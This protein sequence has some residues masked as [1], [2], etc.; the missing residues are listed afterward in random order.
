MQMFLLS[1]IALLSNLSLSN[2]GACQE[3]TCQFGCESYKVLCERSNGCEWD[4]IDWECSTDDA[5]ANPEC[6]LDATTTESPTPEPTP[7]PTC[8][9]PEGDD[10]C[11]NYTEECCE[12]HSDICYYSTSTLCQTEGGPGCCKP[13]TSEPTTSEPTT[14][15]PTTSEPTTSEPTTNEPTT[16]EPTT[17]EPTPKPTTPKPTTPQPTAPTPRPTKPTPQPTEPTPEPTNPTPEPTNPTPEP[18]YPTPEPSVPT[19]DP[20]EWPTPRPTLKSAMKWEMIHPAYTG[21]DGEL[22]WHV[23]YGDFSND[24]RFDKFRQDE[25]WDAKE[26]RPILRSDPQ[27]KQ[28]S[29]GKLYNEDGQIIANTG[30]SHPS[31]TSYGMWL[32]LISIA[33]IVIFACW[34]RSSLA[35]KEEEEMS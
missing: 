4:T 29:N 16:S 23:Y 28:Y 8:A 21:S 19:P 15:E 34:Y 27:F 6:C 33:M 20:V 10:P 2:A 25:K 5:V 22:L 14:Q 12:D 7:A 24:E 31:A 32:V 26:I 17:S 9:E 3:M 18:T 30:E 1:L 11:E 35:S 13:I